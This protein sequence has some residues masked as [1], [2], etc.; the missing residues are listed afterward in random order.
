MNFSLTREII[1]KEWAIDPIYISTIGANLYDFLIK[2][3]SYSSEFEQTQ[4]D[5]FKDN[6]L[7][8][9]VSGELL[10]NDTGSGRIGMKTIGEQIVE[11]DA[12]ENIDAVILIIDSPGGTVDGTIDLV[13]TIKLFSKPIVALIDGYATSAA[14][15]IASATDKIYAM[16][17]FATVGSIG[18]MLSFADVQPYYEKLGYK[19]HRIY[20][21]KSQ[22]KNRLFEEILQGNYENYIKQRLN[23][24]ADKFIADIKELRP[25]I[26]DNQ[27]TGRT[28]FAKDVIGSMVDE[29]GTIDDIVNYLY[30][31]NQNPINMLNTKKREEF[32]AKI[33]ELTSQIQ[34]LTAVK[35]EYEAKIKDIQDKLDKANL[36]KQQLAKDK[37]ETEQQLSSALAEL[38][39]LKSSDGQEAATI[40]K[41]TDALNKDNG[42]VFDENL[43]F[44]ENIKK[45]REIYLGK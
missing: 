17:D 23:P 29:I 33:T 34:E 28:F 37:N 4:I 8:I 11:A 12:D 30:K 7:I 24:L 27:L 18:V 44:Q 10:K 43:D 20:A 1:A 41:D 21:D 2:A 32:E 9:N 25:N 39:E 45:I 5:N 26:Q 36:E 40:D 14:Y 13:N 6:I 19:F 3:Q 15:W 38:E 16:N 31:N 35:E 22:D 42:P